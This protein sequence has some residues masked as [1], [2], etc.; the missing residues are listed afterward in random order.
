M[1]ISSRMI[2]KVVTSL[3]KPKYKMAIAMV[4]VALFVFSGALGFFSSMPHS[5][6]NKGANKGVIS[7]ST[8]NSTAS[9]YQNVVL[10]LGLV[11]LADFPSLN[12]L[13]PINVHPFIVELYLA[14]GYVSYPPSPTYR[15]QLGQSVVAS[16]NYSVW[17]MNLKPN[18]KWD[19]GQPLTSTDL[20]YTL[21]MEEQ[22]H[23]LHFIK[24]LSI[25]NSTAVQISLNISDPGFLNSIFSTVILPYSTF[26]TV[27]ISQ[28]HSFTNFNNIVADGPYVIYNYTS[29]E[30][31]IIMSPNPYYYEGPSHVK[32]VDLY[33]YSSQDSF[34][35][36]L[37]AGDVEGLWTGGAYS[38]V[39]PFI[40]LTGYSVYH[41]VPSGYKVIDF[42]F[43]TA[44]FNNTTFRQALAY[45]TPR[46]FISDSVYGPNPILPEWDTELAADSAL[47]YSPANLPTYHYN[48]NKTAQLMESLG[49]TMSGG[50]WVN[51]T[52]SKVDINIIFPSDQPASDSIATLLS[53]NWTA[54]GFVATIQPVVESTFYSTLISE[55][56]QVSIFTNYAATLP[57]IP[58]DFNI[59]QSGYNLFNGNGTQWFN[60]TYEHAVEQSYTLSPTSAQVAQDM[61]TAAL[62]EAEH[63]IVIPL[64]EEFNWEVVSNNFYWGNQSNYTG[65]FNTQYIVQQQLWVGALHDVYFIGTVTSTTP[66]SALSALDYAIIGVVVAVVVIATV[67]VG[68]N[69]KSK[70]N[71]DKGGK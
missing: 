22:L 6:A 39:A 2:K 65:L 3:G 24:S 23:S 40:N 56:W 15:L 46:Q 58:L 5:S 31:P 44:L 60:K 11:R 63:V 14:F 45:A 35:A 13:A 69:M 68:L 32:D 20:N 19:N 52:G 48:L 49:Y 42:N 66:P 34:D 7:A 30:N 61:R 43:N 54:A 41:I 51:S 18:L 12:V 21:Y 29:G 25:I 64:Y 1:G 59:S 62:I 67:A 33:L 10:K 50:Y 17:T 71:K 53:V 4:I 70:R 27:P 9:N 57:L 38:D 37:E 16:H 55:H 36:A 26:H 8:S 28:I 47:N